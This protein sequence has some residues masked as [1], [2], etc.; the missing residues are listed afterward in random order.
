MVFRLRHPAIGPPHRQMTCASHPPTEPECGRIAHTPPRSGRVR[1]DTTDGAQRFN[2]GFVLV[3]APEQ[4]HPRNEP[5]RQ[6]SERCKRRDDVRHSRKSRRAFEPPS[7]C[8]AEQHPQLHQLRHGVPIFGVRRVQLRDMFVGGRRGSRS[9]ARVV[10][11]VMPECALKAHLLVVY[12]V[13]VG[14]SS[15]GVS[16]GS[17][18]GIGQQKGVAAGRPTILPELASQSS[19]SD[20]G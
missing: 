18:R 4:A 15:V 5:E 13:C 19:V 3:G 12:W 2:T 8:R 9:G 1:P 20:E 11:S 16:R 14:P 10:R 7:R 6:G 17:S